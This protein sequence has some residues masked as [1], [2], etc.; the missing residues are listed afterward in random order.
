MNRK[1]PFIVAAAIAV[2][3][4]WPIADRSMLLY[5]QAKPVVT[6]EKGTFDGEMENPC[7]GE[8]LEISYKWQIINRFTFD[9]NGR[10]HL[11]FHLVWSNMKAIGKDTGIIYT[12]VGIVN[13]TAN[14]A[15]LDPDGNP[16][17]GE[18]PWEY[19]TVGLGKGQ[20][21]GS[22]PNFNIRITYHI[23]VNANGETTT[24]IP[25]VSFRCE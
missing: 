1:T 21:Q 23:T 9:A 5:G 4:L 18:P 13:T 15:E 24:D 17:N 20:S 2:F 16:L 12:G 10:P 11:G 25:R 3:L 22:A 14:G 8:V 7:S 19:T 6:V